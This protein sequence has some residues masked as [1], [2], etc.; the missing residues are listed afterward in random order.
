MAAT[1]SPQ[2]GILERLS[3]VLA[4]EPRQQGAE[5]RV[6]TRESGCHRADQRFPG[7]VLG[8]VSADGL[9]TG[10]SA[11]ALYGVGMTGIPVVNVNN[12]CATGS[13][14]LWLARNAVAPNTS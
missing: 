5:S 10:I 14:A 1:Q 2:G 3:G 9:A 13:T 8:G 7:L 11:I 4:A 6:G 12:N